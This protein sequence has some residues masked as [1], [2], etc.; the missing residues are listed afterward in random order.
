MI[1]EPKNALSE[2]ASDPSFLMI[3]AGAAIWYIGFYML[4]IG[5]LFTTTGFAL[6]CFA[7]ATTALKRPVTTAW[8]GMLLGGLVMVVGSYLTWIFII[9]PMIYVAGAVMVIFFAIPLAVQRGELPILTEI[10]KFWD[11]QSEGKKKA[12]EDDAEADEPEAIDAMEDSEEPEE[13]DE[14]TSD[15]YQ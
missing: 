6:V 5:P 9:G 7:S 1:D 10:Q 4:F 3:L 11:K 14:A 13:P 8:P 12:E 2:I 15:N